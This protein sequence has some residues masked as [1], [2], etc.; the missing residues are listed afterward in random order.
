DIY[1]SQHDY[2]ACAKYLA[3]AISLKPDSVALHLRNAYALMMAGHLAEGWAEFEWRWKWPR[4][5]ARRH[6]DKPEWTGEELSG[7]SI[8][9]FSEQGIGDT[10]QFARYVEIL[11]KRGAQVIVECQKEVKPLIL[12]IPGVGAVR[13]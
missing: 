3:Q 12:T 7:R 1:R 4:M 11:A 6:A 13:A 9:L 5:G 2:A 8:L 10:L